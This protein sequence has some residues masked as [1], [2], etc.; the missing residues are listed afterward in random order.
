MGQN[1][2]SLQGSLAQ[3]SIAKRHKAFYY[4]NMK[5]WLSTKTWFNFI[6]NAPNVARDKKSVD[7]LQSMT[8]HK[9]LGARL[10]NHLM[11]NRTASTL[12]ECV[13]HC[14]AASSCISLNYVKS[15]SVCELNNAVS[16]QCDGNM[17]AS[18]Y[19]AGLGAEYIHYTL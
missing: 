13:L 10:D 4:P 9:S 1:Y 15:G 6:D 14:L 5:P 7:G 17:S 3:K 2:I 8:M 18:D 11:Y 12:R 19:S 16:L